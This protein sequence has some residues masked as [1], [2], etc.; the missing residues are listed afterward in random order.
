MTA[1]LTEVLPAINMTDWES[2]RDAFEN[3]PIGTIALVWSQGELVEVE[4][5]ETTRVAWYTVNARKLNG[6]K[7]RIHVYG[8]CL[9]EV[10]RRGGAT[11]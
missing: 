3:L 4:R 9:V 2:T 1:I 6:R 7:G 5:I 10:I 11:S 8:S